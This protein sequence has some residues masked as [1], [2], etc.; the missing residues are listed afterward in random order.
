M[1]LPQQQLQSLLS[2][3][4][5]RYNDVGEDDVS[6]QGNKDETE[7]DSSFS[8]IDPES[9]RTSHSLS[10]SSTSSGGGSSN[11]SAHENAIA[12][13]STNTNTNNKSIQNEVNVSFYIS[14]SILEGKK[15]SCCFQ[16]PFLLLSN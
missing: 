9:A 16:I 15:R 12:T 1:S 7:D 8:S 6:A 10:I 3:I 4:I 14:Q 13:A 5:D 2:A 11:S